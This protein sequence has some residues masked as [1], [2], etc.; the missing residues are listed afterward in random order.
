MLSRFI[1]YNLYTS[2]H[3][4][5]LFQI[6]SWKY[7][8]LAEIGQFLFNRRANII[9]EEAN[10]CLLSSY[11]GPSAPHHHFSQH[12]CA[13]ILNNLWGLGTGLLYRPARLH[14]LQELIPWNRFLGSFKV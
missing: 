13:E 11:L 2:F 7:P 9:E 4:L 10:S 1:C 3:P 14:S 5:S 12:S 6:I 8:R